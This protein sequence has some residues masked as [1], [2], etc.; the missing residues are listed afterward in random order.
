MSFNWDKNSPYSVVLFYQYISIECVENYL[1]ILRELCGS[2]YLLGRIL[3]SKEGLNGTLAGSDLAIKTFVDHVS[4][5]FPLVKID[6]K[7]SNGSGDSLPF[8]DLHIFEVKELISTG[9]A[10]HFIDQQIQFDPTRF[11][12]LAG[13]GEHLTPQEFH[14]EIEKGDN[15][16]IDVRNE[17]ESAIGKFENAIP[18]NTVVYS[19]SW[20]KIDKIIE[21]YHLS[22]SSTSSNPSSSSDRKVLL[23][24]TGGIRCEKASA[25]MKAKGVPS[26]FQLQGGIHRY[27]ET[28][29]DKG[30]FR[31]KNFV[32]DGRISLPAAGSTTTT[33]STAT[34]TA[35]GSVSETQ[36]S[37]TS[38]STAYESSSAVDIIGRCIACECPYDKFYGARVCT[39]CRSPVLICDVCLLKLCAPRELH[40][41]RHRHLKD[42]YFTNLSAFSRDQLLR[43]VEALRAV[44]ESLIPL[45][46]PEKNR[47][48][49]LRKQIIKIQEHLAKLTGETTQHETANTTSST[50]GSSTGNG[51]D[52][53]STSSSSSSVGT[54]VVG[55]PLQPIIY[56]Q[57]VGVFAFG[58]TSNNGSTSSTCTSTT[59]GKYVGI[60]HHHAT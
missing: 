9:Y 43:Q 58:T 40:C 48:R 2:L 51:N 16:I 18:L 52:N 28:Y 29:K 7:F 21:E 1:T 22:S 44:E 53:S 34:S 12:G 60:I 49:T 33:T 36:S 31:G 35:A 14:S 37:N 20:S 50:S 3:V 4:N 24:C 47:R 26:V 10:K 55:S 57:R 46:R 56:D 59:T 17:M 39:V 45:G 6:W 23:Y 54:P 42:M 13:N 19:E 38:C 41:L 11:G 25:Y 30:Y 5:I 27:L 32:F 8:G 15:I